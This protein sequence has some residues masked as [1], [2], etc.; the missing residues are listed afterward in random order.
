MHV[1]ES[2]KG[3]N[4]IRNTLSLTI[5]RAMKRIQISFNCPTYSL[6]L[7]NIY[8]TFLKYIFVKKKNNQNKTY[9]R[10]NPKNSNL[11]MLL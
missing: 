4:I 6:K 7:I 5:F 2:K 8:N 10:E 11:K 1:E 9:K 3:V